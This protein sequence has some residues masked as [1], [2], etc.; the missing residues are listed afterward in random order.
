MLDNLAFAVMIIL[1]GFCVV[2]LLEEDQNN[3]L[4]KETL[5]NS[6]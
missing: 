3:E 6:D 5:V 2:I 1:M 4:E